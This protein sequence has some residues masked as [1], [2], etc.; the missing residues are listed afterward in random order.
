VETVSVR[1]YEGLREVH[2]V[3]FQQEEIDML[4]S[5]VNG[6]DAGARSG[7]GSGSS[8]STRAVPAPLL[9]G[10][11]AGVLIRKFL[12]NLEATS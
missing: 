1:A 9:L 3:A 10:S 5:I 4:L 12:G 8:D 11:G 6:T 7:S 2:L